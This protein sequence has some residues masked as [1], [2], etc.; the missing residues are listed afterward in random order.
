MRPTIKI[1]DDLALDRIIDGAFSVLHQVG[2]HIGDPRALEMVGSQNGANI[3]GDRVTLSRDL[4]ERCLKTT[5]SQFHVYPQD[6]DEPLI[7]AGDEVNYA[8]GSI[9]PYLYDGESGGLRSP[10]AVDL[11]NH[12][13]VLDTCDHIDFQSGSLVVGDVPRPLTAAYRY[14]LS[15]L[16]CPKPMFGGAIRDDDL[17]VIRDM[18]S[19]IAGGEKQLAEKPMAVI[20]TNPSSPLGLTAMV[21]AHLVYCAETGLPAMLVPIPLAGGSSPVT[22]AGTLV[23]HTAENLGSMVLSQCAK[24]GARVLFGGGPSI[25]DMRKGTAC[26]ASTESVIMGASIGQIAKRLGLPSA[27]NTG[28][29][30]SKRV[31]YQAG[32]ESGIALTAMALA[33]INLIRGS[34]TVEYA[35]VIST[36]KLLIDN[37]ICGM[38]KRMVQPFD[39][40]DDALALDIISERGTSSQGYLSAPH[41]LKWFRSQS[42]VPSDVIDR[43][44][45]REF[46]EK[47]SMDA[48]E[49]AAAKM[50]T[51][52]GS[53]TPRQIDADKKKELDRIMLAYAKG[54]GADGLPITTIR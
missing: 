46:E 40:S 33:G 38:A 53:Y 8:A 39:T 16:Y 12:V 42:F 11:V 19:V 3:D 6:T 9:G 32:E 20:S 18:L 27:T 31:D 14:Y 50:K 13:K 34:G 26:Q 25:M 30:D 1:L 54:F 15:I 36:E 28:R 2:I 48:F 23:Q 17:P 47:G 35:N 52:L 37:E 5:P 49:R 45:R 43:G 22:L 4:V 44:T 7:L 21:A 41:T 29:A 10:T 24:P 51:I